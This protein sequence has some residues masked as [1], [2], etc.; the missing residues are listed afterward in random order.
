MRIG[1]S[2]LEA[3]TGQ[4]T[5]RQYTLPLTRA[6]STLEE[7]PDVVVFVREEDLT[8]FESVC[9]R[10]E[11]VPV[12][13]SFQALEQALAWQE[14]QLPELAREHDL[15]LVHLPDYR[16]LK[17]R[18]ECPLVGTLHELDALAGATKASWTQKLLESFVPPKTGRPVQK[19]IVAN[20]HLARECRIR[21][22]VTEEQLAIIPN[23]IDH[24]RF[25]PGPAFE[26]KAEMDA[27]FDLVEP[28]FLCL[29]RLDHPAANHVSLIAAF[30]RF[31][32]RMKSP[33]LLVLVGDDG[34]G[35]EKVHE[36]ILQSP[37][38]ADIRWTAHV[39]PDDLATLY[40]AADV[41]VHPSLLG[42][43]NVALLD[44]MA[45]GC[46]VIC[47]TRGALAEVV[48]EASSLIDPEDMDD[49]AGKLAAM[50]GSLELR[51][52]WRAASLSRA[53]QFNWRQTAARTRA[54]YERIVWR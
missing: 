17:W 30:N 3:G 43:P 39:P 10:L 23:G 4:G 41:L 45:C 38:A 9:P 49:I 19:L 36:A 5:T 24:E 37:Y 2:V 14:N 13:G 52:R 54:L 7:P 29:G 25:F 12:P 28:F 21:L 47:S 48:G 26:A 11:C 51:Q 6:L 22:G 32:R 50:A 15:D 27:R 34:T 46:P 35:S 8:V 31:K 53:K 33:W 44:A 20:E 40:R 18:G 1:F 42:E 16:P